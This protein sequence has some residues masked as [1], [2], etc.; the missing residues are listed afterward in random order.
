MTTVTT[1]PTTP[2]PYAP[3]GL[4]RDIT[5]EKAAV[6]QNAPADAQASVKQTL[7]SSPDN[8]FALQSTDWS[9]MQKAV[10]HGLQLPITQGDFTDKYGA[11]D[12]TADVQGAI[13]IFNTINTLLTQYGDPSSIAQDIDQYTSMT[14][15]PTAIFA[16]TVWLAAQVELA[17][18]NIQ[19]EFN[20]FVQDVLPSLSPDDAATALLQLIQAPGGLL[21]TVSNTLLPLTKTYNTTVG[22]YYKQ[23]YDALLNTN[24]AG[25]DSLA[26]Y[27]AQ[28][29]NVL[30]AAQNDVTEI[31]S[32]IATLQS[33]IATDNQQYLAF[34]ITASVSPALSLLPPLFFLQGLI[35]AAV[36]GSLAG[37]WKGKLDALNSQLQQQ[38]AAEQQ[39]TQ[40]VADLTTFNQQASTIGT[41]GTT[42]LND[43]DGLVKAWT[44]FV[45]TLN[46]AVKDIQTA[47]KDANFK[48]LQE[49]LISAAC[50]EWQTAI[51]AIENFKASG[52]MIQT[53]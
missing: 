45:G 19:N 32:Q 16:Y 12:D 53:S 5:A 27:L 7:A 35:D 24:A 28:D 29:N 51:T 46:T 18:Q 50:T 34:T 52:F 33:E 6:I 25:P 49:G 47:Q 39:K 1:T 31:S 44:N 2:N 30:T 41:Y 48:F 23:L 15:P 43:V 42:F 9:N 4:T 40:L 21:D 14:D 17:A 8:V 26:K 11:F 36:F 10:T 3:V 37:V 13:Q 20:A 22:T 38:Q